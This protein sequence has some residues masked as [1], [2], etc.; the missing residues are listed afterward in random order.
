MVPCLHVVS[1]LLSAQTQGLY[2]CQVVVTSVAGLHRARLTLQ[3]MTS[4]VCSRWHADYV[5]VRP[6]L[7]SP[8]DTCPQLLLQIAQDWKAS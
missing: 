4:A 7:S 2:W 3:C 8:F 6:A 1:G 5:T